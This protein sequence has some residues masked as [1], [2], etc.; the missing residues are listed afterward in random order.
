MLHL[1]VICT[2]TLQFPQDWELFTEM[3]LKNVQMLPYKLH[4]GTTVW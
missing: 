1:L 2:A 3:L 4:L